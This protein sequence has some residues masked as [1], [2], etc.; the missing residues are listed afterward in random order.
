[1]RTGRGSGG[2]GG[3]SRAT[4]WATRAGW[5]GAVRLGTGRFGLWRP[6]SDRLASLAQRSRGATTSGRMAARSTAFGPCRQRERTSRSAAASVGRWD[7]LLGQRLDRRTWHTAASQEG[8]QFP[9]DDKGKGKE[10]SLLATSN[11]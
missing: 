7:I 8:C 6:S 2:C 4:I 3:T 10:I 9:A 11:V 1:R 5:R